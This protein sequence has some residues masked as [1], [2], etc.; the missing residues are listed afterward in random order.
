M[1]SCVAL[2]IQS[3]L[4]TE[5]ENEKINS[6]TEVF[7]LLVKLLD[8]SIRRVGYHGLMFAPTEILEVMDAINI[9]LPIELAVLV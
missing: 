1:L 3:Y 5:D 9:Q 2:M 8:C 6:G 4:V 7:D